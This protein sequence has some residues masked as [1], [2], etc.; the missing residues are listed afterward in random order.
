MI[1]RSLVRAVGPERSSGPVPPGAVVVSPDRQA[2]LAA[3]WSAETIVSLPCGRR[4]LL[5]RWR[6]RGP[7]AQR[8]GRR[9]GLRLPEPAQ[10]TGGHQQRHDH[11]W[12]SERQRRHHRHL[13]QSHPG[14]L[15][16]GECNPNAKGILVRWHTGTEVELLGF[17]VYRSRGQSWRRIHLDRT[18]RRLPPV[19]GQGCAQRRH[20]EL[21]RAGARERVGSRWIATISSYAKGGD[22]PE[23]NAISWCPG[24][25]HSRLLYS[26]RGPPRCHPD[27]QQH[28]ITRDVP[29]C[30]PFY[31]FLLR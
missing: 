30:A 3:Y 11:G 20:N 29:P 31:F 22:R 26:S 23:L 16:F 10:P 13:R 15:R 12:P 1:S 6:R 27:G 28:P 25:I 17:H 24:S 8:F 14:H 5:R 19:P 4:R 9:R 2:I 18:A 21:V 7:R